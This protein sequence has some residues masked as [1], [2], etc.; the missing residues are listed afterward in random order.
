[1]LCKVF[2]Q[3][4]WVRNMSIWCGIIAEDFAKVS[5]APGPRKV[6]HDIDEDFCVQFILDTDYVTFWLIESGQTTRGKSLH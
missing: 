3:R 5:I 4:Q 2:P 1:M 6:E